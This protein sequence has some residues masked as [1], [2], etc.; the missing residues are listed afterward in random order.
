[1][2]FTVLVGPLKRCMG[3]IVQVMCSYLAT[4]SALPVLLGHQHFSML[5]A[6]VVRACS[7]HAK[8]GK[9]LSM[10]SACVL[11]TQYLLT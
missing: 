2:V 4:S 5:G 11:L 9:S 8:E 1:M 6:G 7:M 10:I 3:C